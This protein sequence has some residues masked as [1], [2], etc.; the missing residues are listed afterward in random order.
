MCITTDDGA[1]DHLMTESQSRIPENIGGYKHSVPFVWK[2]VCGVI[3]GGRLVSI[4]L[5]L[6]LCGQMQLRLS[7]KT[8]FLYFIYICRGREP[9]TL[10]RSSRYLEPSAD[11][12][13]VVLTQHGDCAWDWGWS[14]CCCILRQ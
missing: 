8:S 4:R 1:Y 6:F 2:K 3:F 11:T 12:G 7:P 13:K 5:V 10:V 14:C 9:Q